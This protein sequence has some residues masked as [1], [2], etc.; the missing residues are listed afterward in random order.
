MSSPSLSNLTVVG[1][2][3]LYASVFALGWDK[4][5]MPDSAIVIKCHVSKMYKTY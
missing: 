3:L 1:C 4:T 2:L 5:N